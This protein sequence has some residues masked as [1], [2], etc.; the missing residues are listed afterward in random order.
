LKVSN[1]PF[2]KQI[3]LGVRT[4]HGFSYF[5]KNPILILFLLLKLI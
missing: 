3:M 1:S 5:K 2:I 4:E